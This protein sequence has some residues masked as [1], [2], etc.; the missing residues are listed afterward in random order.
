[1]KKKFPN[2]IV[3]PYSGKHSVRGNESRRLW[4]ADRWDRIERRRVEAVLALALA[5][6]WLGQWAEPA[7]A[8]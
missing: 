6:A 8:R 4:A 5:V 3:E 2:V 7:R 1:M